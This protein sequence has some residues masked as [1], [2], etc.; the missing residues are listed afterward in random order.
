MPKVIIDSPDKDG[1]LTNV[2]SGIRIGDGVV[3][4]AGHNIYHYQNSFGVISKRVPFSLTGS[5]PF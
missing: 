5:V 3:L 4:T 1:N 2:G